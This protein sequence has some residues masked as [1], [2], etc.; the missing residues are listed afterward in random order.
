MKKFTLLLAVLFLILSVKADVSNNPD[1]LK[2]Q[3]L[4]TVKQKSSIQK[5]SSPSHQKM[6][7]FMMLNQ[8]TFDINSYK[9]KLDSVVTTILNEES[10][11]W[12]NDWKDEFIYDSQNRPKELIGKE[13]DLETKEWNIE[14]KSV[15]TYNSSGRIEK[16]NM[17]FRNPDTNILLNETEMRYF[18]HQTG[19]LDSLHIYDSE[20]G[21]EWILSTRNIY[22]YDNDGKITQSVNWIFDEE[23]DEWIQ[24]MTQKYKYNAQGR[25][26]E[27]EIIM[28]FDDEEFL[29]GNTIYVW[30]SAGKLES[31]ESSSINF[32]EFTLEKTYKTVFLYNSSNSLEKET[33]FKWNKTEGK[34]VEDY[35]TEYS[36]GSTNF[37]EILYP[38][39]NFYSSTV[40]EPYYYSFD[41][42]ILEEMVSKYSEG[43]FMLKEKSKYYYSN[44]TSTGFAENYGTKFMHYP[45]PVN[46]K[47]SFSWPG[48]YDQL[49]LELYQINGI[50]LLQQSIGINSPVNLSILNNGIYIYKLSIENE[51]LFSG[52]LIKR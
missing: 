26:S 33:E 28:M 4:L 9:S 47:V 52:K 16:L 18:Y 14:D 40:L 22:K 8:V 11:L 36:F 3:E 1:N 17:H 46:D 39:F 50:R 29:I 20:D 45:N 12:I 34:W 49:T 31:I 30:N 27:L 38:Y 15:L 35:Q 10:N 48:N 32:M 7:S 13:W 6:I 21:T 25:L 5:L 44:I 24:M 43:S 42:Q 51:V 2:L 19:R 37:A 41:K 23:E